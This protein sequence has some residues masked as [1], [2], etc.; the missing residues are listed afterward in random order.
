MQEISESAA[1]PTTGGY[2]IAVLPTITAGLGLRLNES[3]LVAPSLYV[4]TDDAEGLLAS[5]STI[6]DVDVLLESV[7][8]G[9]E[10]RLLRIFLLRGGLNHNLL[11]LGA[12]IDLAIIRA[13]LA[14]FMSPFE[15]LDTGVSGIAVRGAVKL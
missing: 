5:L 11:S 14:L 1:F 13:D 12:G 15:G 3:G 9:A 7:Q 4:Q 10:L 6:D 8:A 2:E